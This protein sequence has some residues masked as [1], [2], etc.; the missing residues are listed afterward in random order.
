MDHH[1]PAMTG[2]L[3]D[4][5]LYVPIR[6]RRCC[7]PR[8][9]K[10]YENLPCRKLLVDS[11]RPEY[12]KP[13]T[14]DSHI[15]SFE[16]HWVGSTILY[17]QKI[18]LILHDI[19][20]T[21]FVADTAD[22]DVILKTSLMKTVQWL[23]DHDDYALCDGEYANLLEDGTI[24]GRNPGTYYAMTTKQPYSSKPS[25]R[26]R[27][28]LRYY[29]GRNHATM[30]TSVSKQIFQVFHDHYNLQA[31]KFIDRVF[32]AT[33]GIKGNFKTLPLLYQIKTNRGRLTHKP[34]MMK[35]LRFGIRIKEHLDDLRPVSEILAVD[36]PMDI[37]EA[38]ALV[39][40]N[41]DEALRPKLRFRRN[42][43]YDD[44]YVPSFTGNGQ[45][46][47]ITEVIDAIRDHDLDDPVWPRALN[48]R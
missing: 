27:N 1:Q 44:V 16:Y 20:N 28:A 26:L 30:R 41:M 14:K 3:D 25:E 42:H 9:L 29:L 36:E 7:V 15:G 48:P 5:T 21:P 35:E 33:A 46:Q 17:H 8:V 4:L 32:T 12:G 19:V 43:Q 6:D 45:K 2:T 10:Y 18:H 38:H 11:T 40:A 22:D 23:R 37:E 39:K 47:Q 34:R 31:I 13:L 24:K